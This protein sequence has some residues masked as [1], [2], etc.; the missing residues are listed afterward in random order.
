MGRCVCGERRE[1][2]GKVGARFLVLVLFCFVLFFDSRTVAAVSISRGWL[3]P[4]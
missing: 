3:R 4:R 1:T 2:E